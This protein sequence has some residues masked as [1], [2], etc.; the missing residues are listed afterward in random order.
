[1]SVK[2]T[3][4]SCRSGSGSCCAPVRNASISPMQR[5]GVAGERGVVDALELDE[6]RAR[7]L[8]GDEAGALDRPER[9]A[10]AVQDEGRH[11]DRRQHVADVDL[12]GEPNGRLRHRRARREPLVARPPA[13]EVGSPSTLGA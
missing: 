2:S 3:V 8:L 1:M 5:F 4:S 10:A 11:R 9:V 12:G 7:D 13:R 6:L